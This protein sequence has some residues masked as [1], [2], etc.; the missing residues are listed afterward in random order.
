MG[1]RLWGRTELDT[2]EVTQQQQQQQ[3]GNEPHHRNPEA[4]LLV[5]YPAVSCT[6]VAAALAGSLRV[7]VSE[8]SSSNTAT[9]FNT[10]L[11][12]MV[13]I[14]HFYNLFLN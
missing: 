2:T 12:V 4:R 10:L 13:I 11:M 1:W 14:T 9:A 8:K 6:T 3:T 7:G 5:R